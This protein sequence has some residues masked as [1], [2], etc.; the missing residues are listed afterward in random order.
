MQAD[1]GVEILSTIQSGAQGKDVICFIT[2]KIS[3]KFIQHCGLRS[4]TL[5]KFGQHFS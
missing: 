3:E 5:L 2:N 1:I 4:Y